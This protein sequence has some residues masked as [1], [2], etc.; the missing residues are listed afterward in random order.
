MHSSK[1]RR[2]NPHNAKFTLLKCTIQW[3]L[4]RS[5]CDRHN[6]AP[7]SRHTPPSP[8]PWQP[9]ICFPTLHLPVLE[10]SIPT[11]S[12]DTQH[13]VPVFFPSM[14]CSEGSSTLKRVSVPHSARLSHVP[15]HGFPRTLWA[16]QCGPV[17]LPGSCQAPPL[18]EGGLRAAGTAPGG[19]N[20]LFPVTDER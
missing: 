11:K 19:R 10:H 4:V 20:P 14:P 12:H 13:F 1:K 7:T 2:R 15:S 3:H 16:S 5:Q 18:Q 9:P 6:S 8:S 17:C